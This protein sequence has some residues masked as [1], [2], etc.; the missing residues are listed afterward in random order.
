MAFAR[1]AGLLL[2]AQLLQVVAA[3]DVLQL[4]ES[5]FGAIPRD[6]PHLV[7]FTA[8]WC[9]HCKALTAE[10]A[11]AA[12]LLGDK[13]VVAEVDAVGCRGERNSREHNYSREHCSS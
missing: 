2:A 13:A 10:L 12:D 5:G 7:A 3:G 9:G 8:P 4:T 11:L 1:A 6:V